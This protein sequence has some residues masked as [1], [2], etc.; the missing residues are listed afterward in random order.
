MT[1]AVSSVNAQAAVM[2]QTAAR[3]ESVNQSLETM[4][5]RLMGELDALKQQ[6]NGAGGRSFDQT[7][8]EWAYDQARLHAA[9]S[10]TAAAIRTS[11]RAYAATD[12]EAAG[13]A[14]SASRG[15]LTL[16]L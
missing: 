12:T 7:R 1:D 6:W 11:G 4:L 8:L 15:G 5:R 3:F 9:L 10:E 2:E 14:H 13:R 16:P